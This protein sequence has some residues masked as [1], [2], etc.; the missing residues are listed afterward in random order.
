MKYLLALKRLF[1]PQK[2][3]LYRT[4]PLRYVFLHLIILATLLA[5]PAA[6]HFYQ[7]MTSLSQLIEEKSD[8]IPAFTI[9]NGHLELPDHQ[10]TVIH[11]N[12]GSV[13]FTEQ[14]SI[15][16]DN[17]FTFSRN[18]IHIPGLDPISYQNISTIT[19]RSSLIDTLKTFT[20]S[21]YFYFMLVLLAL[22]LIQLFIILIKLISI[23]LVAHLAALLFKKKSRFMNWLKITSF[24]LTIPVLLQYIG[25]LV[26]NTLSYPL[27][28]CIIILLT[29]LTVY[30]LPG[31]KKAR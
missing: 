17:A 29:C 22:I 27:S 26:P 7:S 10:K 12:Q 18:Q 16:S 24:L 21:V 3:P 13:I 1:T 14:E 28:W 20:S 15:L 30:H 19:D 4:T 6:S 9:Q 5:A 2:Y 8:A 11:L 31:N 25:L 23:S